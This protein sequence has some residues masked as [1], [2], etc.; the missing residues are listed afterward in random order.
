MSS[1]NNK[2]TKLEEYNLSSA[3]YLKIT[4]GKLPL[5]LR[6]KCNGL[7]SSISCSADRRPETQHAGQIQRQWT[8]ACSPILSHAR[9][10]I[11]PHVQMR[12][13]TIYRLFIIV[14]SAEQIILYSKCWSNLFFI[15][16]VTVPLKNKNLLISSK[17]IYS[18]T[19]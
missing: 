14:L 10:F 2:W 9:I 1:Q 3:I 11:T 5:P 8:T 12:T 19:K 15:F 18:F 6:Y 4:H 7:L 17:L 16:N 13:I